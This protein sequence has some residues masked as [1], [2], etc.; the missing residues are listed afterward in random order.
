M[1]PVKFLVNIDVRF[2][3]EVFKRSRIGERDSQH[4]KRVVNRHF[5]F[6]FVVNNG[7]QAVGDNRCVDLDADCIFEVSPELFDF[8]MLLHPFETVR[9]TNGFYKEGR[10]LIQ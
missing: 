8:Q 7:Y 2:V 1:E 6:H 4:L 10:H 3:E 9:R 5:E